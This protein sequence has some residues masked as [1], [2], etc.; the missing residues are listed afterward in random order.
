MGKA[1]SVQST[2][3]VNQY[4]YLSVPPLPF[5][6]RCGAVRPW[7]RPVGFFDGLVEHSGFGA[8]KW[9][10]EYNCGVAVVAVYVGVGEWVHSIV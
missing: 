4:S 5:V 10:T 7:S 3:P 6:R 1:Y 9:S 8:G 2:I